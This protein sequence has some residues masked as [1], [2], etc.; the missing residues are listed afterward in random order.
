MSGYAPIRQG[1]D[2][3]PSQSTLTSVDACD[4]CQLHSNNCQGPGLD[5]KLRRTDRE[6][7]ENGIKGSSLDQKLRH[8]D[9]ERSE[10]GIEKG[11]KMDT[12]R[13]RG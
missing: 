2:A 9:R 6:R 7:S 10:H 13:K 8:A 5:Q 12:E 11:T 1:S 3:G 4:A